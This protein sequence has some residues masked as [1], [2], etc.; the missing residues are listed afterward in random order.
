MM[1]GCRV[2][3]SCW[4]AAGTLQIAQDFLSTTFPAQGSLI[5]MEPLKNWHCSAQLEDLLL[6]WGSQN[7]SRVK[8]PGRVILLVHPQQVLSLGGI[9]SGGVNLLVLK[10][11][12]FSSFTSAFLVL[13]QT[14]QLKCGNENRRGGCREQQRESKVVLQGR[15]KGCHAGTDSFPPGKAPPW[16]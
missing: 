13:G 11:S 8:L 12:S 4:I 7:P 1:D 2:S 3:I 10:Y 14:Q 6:A 9:L 16:P 15:P 5:L